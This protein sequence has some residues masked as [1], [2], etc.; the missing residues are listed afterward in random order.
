VAGIPIPERSQLT[1]TDENVRRVQA[2][3]LNLPA[4]LCS[5]TWRGRSPGFD[6]QFF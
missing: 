5:L 4:T 1:E 2:N 6:E 3:E